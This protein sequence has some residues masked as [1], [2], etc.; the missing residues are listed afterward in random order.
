MTRGSHMAEKRCRVCGE[1]KSLDQFHRAKGMRDG[2]RNECLDCF[3]LMSR[4]RYKRDP[5]KAIAQV[6]RWQ[7]ANA[8]RLNAYRRERRLEP[9][10]K[11]QQR[12]GYY[13][14][15][16]G[17]SADEFD[18]MLDAQGG[19][20]AICGVQPERL[21]SMHVDHDHEHGHLRGL[22]CLSC[23]QGLGQFRDDPSLLLRAVVYLRQ[24]RAD[25]TRAV[26]L[27]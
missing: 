23:N 22:L 14:R 2:H 13:R 25:G 11:R 18:A 27:A 21:A 9:A 7:Q 24:R 26:N 1:S 16:Y 4:E 3:R 10:V 15:T 8:D 19:R 6:K 20:C 5:A 12:D 17:I